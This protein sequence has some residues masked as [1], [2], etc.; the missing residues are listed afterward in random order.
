VDE[1][2]LYAA[3]GAGFD[4]L[5]IRLAVLAMEPVLDSNW[6][7]P[8]WAE[9]V[10]EFASVGTALHPASTERLMEYWSHGEGAAKVR[11]EEPCAFCRCLTHLAKY[12]PKD[13]K[14]LCANLEHRATGHWPNPEHHR[15]HHC[16]C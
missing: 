7:V 5:L 15:T 6:T 12:F 9:G 4:D 14:G 2:E 16:P 10:D 3:P 1:A 11:W 8:G 13:P